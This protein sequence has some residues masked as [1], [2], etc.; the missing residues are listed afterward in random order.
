MSI[1]H[2]IRTIALDPEDIDAVRQLGNDAAAIKAHLKTL[3]SEF[4]AIRAKVAEQGYDVAVK[5]DVAFSARPQPASNMPVNRP[6]PGTPQA[7]PGAMLPAAARRLEDIT[8]DLARISGVPVRQGRLKSSPAGKVAGQFDRTQGVM[9]LREMSDFETMTH[10]TAH[11]LES[12]WGRP[13][14]ALKLAHRAELEPMAYAGANPKQQLSEGFAEF[15]RFYVT[16]PNYA[17]RTA[18]NFYKEFENFLLSNHPEKL[19]QLRDVS[20]AY[21]QW[22]MT[23]SRAAVAADITTSRR[24][25][26]MG[27]TTIADAVEEVR[28]GGAK[29]AMGTWASKGYSAFVDKLNPIARSV[30]ELMKIYEKNYG[31]ALN[32]TSA[33][34]PYRLARLL[35]DAYSA[36]HIDAMHGV[37][38]YRS[39]VSEGP[40]LSDAIGLALGENWRGWDDDLMADFAA[41]LVSRRAVHEY[42]RFRAGE[43]PN[44]PGKFTEGDYRVTIEEIEKAHPHWVDA[45]AQV[46]EWG[47]NMLRKKY[48]AGF[49]TQKLYEEL[50]ARPD[51]VPFM[52]DLT[53]LD[54]EVQAAPNQVLRSS[55]LKAFKGSK[56]SVINPLESML[57]DSYHT[58]ALIKRNDIFKALDDLGEMAG[59]GR[60]AIVERI[61]A[62]Q[63]KGTDVD[64][65]QVLKNAA[66]QAGL[67]PSDVDAL[68]MFVDDMLGENAKATVFKVGEINEKGEP[69]IYVWRDGKKKALR[70]ADGDFGREMY[71][72]LSG[73]NKEVHNLFVTAMSLP[74]TV[75]RYSI[76]TSPPFMFANYLRDQ[77]SAW[78][79]T[80]D[81]YIPVV[82]GLKGMRDEVT[83]SEISRIYNSFGGIMGGADVASLDKGR[84][85]RDLK[86]LNKKGYKVKR[87]TDIRGFN[88]V[89]G[90][91]ETGTRLGVFSS[92]YKRAIKDGLSEYEAAVEAAF[93]AR[94]LI[95]FGRHGSQTHTVRRLVTFLNASIQGLDKT[96]R[97]LGAEGAIRK[98]IAPYVNKQAGRPLSAR[99]KRA[100]GTAAKAWA[101]LLTTGLFGLALAYAQRENPDYE[102]VSDYLRATHWVYVTRDAENKVMVYALPKPFELGFISNLFERTFDAT[103]GR[104]PIALQAFLD[105]LYEVTAPPTGIALFDVT[106]EIKHNV[107]NQGRPI[108]GP[109]IAG[110]EPWRQ[111]NAYTSELAKN[112]GYVT[113]L[114]PAKIDHAIQGFGAS[115][116]RIIT[117]ASNA[118]EQEKSTFEMVTDSVK[119]RFVRDV[120]RGSTSSRAYWGLM[121]Q[122]TGPMSQ[123]ATTY[124]ELYE[125]GQISEA[126]NLLAPK[127][128]NTKAYAMLTTHFPAKAERM[129][130]LIRTKDAISVISKLKREIAD[131]K[132]E[133]I[134]SAKEEEVDVLAMT[135]SQRNQAQEQLARLSMMEARNA[136]ITLQIPG[137]TQKKYMD[138]EALREEIRLANPELGAEIDARYEE[139]KVYDDMAVRENWPEL[140]NRVLTEGPEAYLDDL[141]AGFE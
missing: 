25:T 1:D 70:L 135:A 94:D 2:C 33:Q 64:V 8:E 18:P 130:P 19:Q 77:V 123:A 6:Q 71:D 105:G 42:Q 4:E 7:Q 65:D 138:S 82:S 84:V 60:G 104:N 50:S 117:D 89:I 102:E 52:R 112:L 141:T 29:V 35:Q 111:Y 56:R 67:N 80:G 44:P 34:D 13:L 69:I 10:E 57:A 125:N 85:M 133:R 12:E 79:L 120:T 92:A 121:S 100:L 106:S 66:K 127:D 11:A 43:I 134:E 109:D 98:A 103:Y 40:S 32:I 75:L 17:R 139:K 9:R 131:N 20:R 36:G 61:P 116:G 129:H 30:D 3:E 83:Q 78:V 16:T 99:D 97:T 27:S 48:E 91:T 124:K 63:L 15:M 115:W 126:A 58:N 114:S 62:H 136:L 76:T 110:Y 132:V 31:R 93:Q 26:I 88:E 53:D 140:K 28:D 51:Y 21:T 96:I 24:N 95:D 113:G 73:M 68:T 5:P 107:D 90:I 23:P 118:R 47:R 119:N 87:F 54:R 81:G 22:T 14:N 128:E 101:K 38:P 108:V 122:T 74:S 49:I 37:V 46:H 59:P 39:T 41:Y 45:A 55:I 72:A 86:A 137:W